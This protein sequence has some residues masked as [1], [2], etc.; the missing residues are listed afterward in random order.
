VLLVLIGDLI[1]SPL[2]W[3]AVNKWL[4]EFTVKI[5]ISWSVFVMTTAATL[6]IA[7]LTVAYLCVKTA[8]ANPVKS[9]RTE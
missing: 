4:Q 5:S 3:Y 1:A 8:T 2:A 7:V 6:F 9:L